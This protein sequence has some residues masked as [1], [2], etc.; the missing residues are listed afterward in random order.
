MTFSAPKTKTMTISNKSNL[1]QHPDL[2]L[3]GHVIKRVD[4]HKHLGVI[5]SHNLRWSS[6]I[7]ELVVKTSTKLDL[8]RG[9]KFKL[10]RRSLETIYTSFIRPC[11]EYADVLWASTYDSDLMK[12]Q[13]VHI[14]AMRIVTGATEKSNIRNLYEETGLISLQ[15]RQMMHE[16]EAL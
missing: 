12:L 6:Q 8:M 2:H 3:E 14:D 1:H 7:S 9:F 13:V 16:H 5:L 11:L 10:D 4:H 15:E